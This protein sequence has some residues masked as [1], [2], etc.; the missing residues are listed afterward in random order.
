LKFYKK[1]LFLQI[2]KNYA[3]DIIPRL[4]KNKAVKPWLTN[5]SK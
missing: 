4:K 1:K 2:G 3:S 5:T